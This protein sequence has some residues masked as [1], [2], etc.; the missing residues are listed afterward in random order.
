M[1][2]LVALG[3][4]STLVGCISYDIAWSLLAGNGPYFV[5]TKPP[6]LWNMGKGEWRSLSDQGAVQAAPT[7]NFSSNRRH[8][9]KPTDTSRVLL[10]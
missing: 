1:R 4:C 9:P 10:G 5:S 8:G 6:S 2:H 7:D 3:L